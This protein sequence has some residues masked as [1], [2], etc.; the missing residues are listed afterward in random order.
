MS[1]AMKLVFLQIGLVMMLIAVG[2]LTFHAFFEKRPVSTLVGRIY[3][4]QI[5]MRPGL[6]IEHP[7][8][9]YTTTYPEVTGQVRPAGHYKQIAPGKWQR[10]ETQKRWRLRRYD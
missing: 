8:G 6:V 2:W 7:S 10:V 4:D 3:D 9:K 5:A 1:E